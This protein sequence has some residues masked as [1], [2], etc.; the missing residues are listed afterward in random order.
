MKTGSIYIIRNTVNDKV[1]IGQTTMS[2]HDRFV[3]HCKPSTHK[4][5]GSYKIYNAMLKY[6]VEKFCVETLESDI[7]IDKLDEK[8]IKYIEKFNSYLNGYNSTKGGDGRIICK[9]DDEEKV[10]EMAKSGMTAKEIA[11]K[12]GVH[13]E[14]IYRLLRK[15]NFRYHVDPN[16]VIEMSE[17][18]MMTKDIAKELGIDKYTVSRILDK[19]G[20]RK[21]KKPLRN[22]EDIDYESLEKDYYSQMTISSI[23][24]K[25]GISRTV[26]YRI[27]E[28]RRM[29]SRPQ[30]YKYKIRNYD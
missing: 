16:K 5:R 8:E 22:R 2:V 12:Y 23:C 1:Y 21:H 17:S 26:F 19:K 20:A 7:P 30:I 10:V 24:E 27:K 3:A 28:Q 9:I 6:G 25:Y 29:K 14:T 15:K 4:Q 13:K 18:G 11:E